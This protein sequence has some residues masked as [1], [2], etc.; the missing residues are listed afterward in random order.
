MKTVILI[1]KRGVTEIPNP[2]VPATAI[3][4]LAVVSAA[5]YARALAFMNV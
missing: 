5:T 1:M 2:A 4:R 3:L